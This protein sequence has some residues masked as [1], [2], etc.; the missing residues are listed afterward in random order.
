MV[1]RSIVQKTF[2]PSYNIIIGFQK[3]V[4]KRSK[5][6]FFIFK[7]DFSINCQTKTYFLAYPTYVPNFN[8]KLIILTKW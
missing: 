3:T 5:M 2:I 4:A 8:Q 1:K 6:I 7:I